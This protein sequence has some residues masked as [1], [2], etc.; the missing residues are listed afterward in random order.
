MRLIFLY[1]LPATGKLTV[2]QELSR[3]TGLRLFHNHLA[4][5][6][7]LSVFDFGT[8]PFVELREQ[9]WLSV[10][11]AASESGLSDMIFTFNPENSVRPEFVP[12]VVETVERDGGSVEF[13]ELTCPLPEVKRRLESASR[14]EFRKLTSVT[15]FEQLYAAGV[16]ETARMPAPRVSVDTSLVAPE[17][18]AEAIADGLKLS[19]V[20]QFT[21]PQA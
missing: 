8:P 18:A 7:L 4:V 13:V 1:G 2:A 17:A 21:E 19:L 12:R 14:A 6:L 10:F 16:F 9:I 3:L 20:S 5:D 15:L 11:A